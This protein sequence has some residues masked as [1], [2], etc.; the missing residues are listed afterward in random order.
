MDHHSVI[1]LATSSSQAENIVDD[2]R[3]SLFADE[4]ISVLIA[5]E[6]TETNEERAMTSGRSLSRT[7][8]DLPEV[9]T[10]HLPDYGPFLAAGP[11]AGAIL[12]GIP[13]CGIAEGLIRLG[14]PEEEARRYESHLH[15]GQILIAVH[16]EDSDEVSF[17]K[18]IF[19]A[20]LVQD[21]CISSEW[22][23]PCI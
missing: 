14:I 21:I 12:H 9:E 22:S 17:A 16:S 6:E 7:L 3:L 23:L 15:D 19:K 4:N 8:A 10:I 20:G 1:C 2:L 5:H 13:A 18:K 11:L